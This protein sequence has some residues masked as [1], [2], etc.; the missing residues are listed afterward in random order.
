MQFGLPQPLELLGSGAGI[1]AFEFVGGP[2]TSSDSRLEMLA[3]RKPVSF[4]ADGAKYLSTRHLVGL[5]VP[6]VVFVLAFLNRVRPNKL[7]I[8]S[9]VNSYSP[10]AHQAHSNGR[11]RLSAPAISAMLPA[12]KII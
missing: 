8:T 7:N 10:M 11:M 1:L 6:L 2:R 5:V 4:G 12:D 3:R 9:I